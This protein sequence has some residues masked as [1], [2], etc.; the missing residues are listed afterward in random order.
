MKEKTIKNPWSFTCPSYDNRSGMAVNAGSH[1]GV[2]KTNPVGHQNDPKQNVACL[3][4]GSMKT[5]K[6]DQ[7]G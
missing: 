5:L 3:P 2:G 1:H 6:D 7:I 4:R